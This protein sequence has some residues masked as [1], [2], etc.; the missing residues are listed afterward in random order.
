MLDW[1]RRHLHFGPLRDEIGQYLGLD[2]RS[3]RVS[4]PLAHELE[5]PLGYPT[6]RVLILDYLAE[7]ED[8]TTVTGWDSK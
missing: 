8:E 5:R 1:I 7:R 6:C 2:R 4:N 3:W